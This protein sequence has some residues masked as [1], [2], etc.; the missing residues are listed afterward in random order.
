[1]RHP[2]LHRGRLAQPVFLPDARPGVG[3]QVGAGPGNPTREYI[4]GVPFGPSHRDSRAGRRGESRAGPQYN[5][6]YNRKAQEP[7]ELSK[8]CLWRQTSRG[9]ANLGGAESRGQNLPSAAWEAA[10]ACFYS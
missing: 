2:A 1:M 5:P 3:G 7:P 9:I 6:Q 4:G 8:M 10:G